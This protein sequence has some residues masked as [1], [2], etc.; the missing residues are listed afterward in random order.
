MQQCNRNSAAGPQG[1]T[2]WIYYVS[3]YDT[4]FNTNS[5]F[6]LGKPEATSL[7]LWRLVINSEIPFCCHI[8]SFP[9]NFVISLHVLSWSSF[10]KGSSTWARS[11]L[12]NAESTALTNARSQ[13][14]DCTRHLE[15]H[16]TGA[17]AIQKL[18][19]TRCLLIFLSCC[20]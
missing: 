20:A 4:L 10:S 2:P 3:K 5:A 8:L 7:P 1:S 12:A 6:T 16:F 13:R 9:R 11:A 19:C 17:C 18:N 15:H 14:L